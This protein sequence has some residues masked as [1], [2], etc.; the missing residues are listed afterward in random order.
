MSTAQ[1]QHNDKMDVTYNT[2]LYETNRQVY[3]GEKKNNKQL[4]NT[5][6]L[7]SAVQRLKTFTNVMIYCYVV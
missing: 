3:C 7:N 6:S 1:I 4:D 5:K 2:L